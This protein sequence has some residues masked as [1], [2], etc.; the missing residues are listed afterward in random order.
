MSVAVGDLSW[1]ATPDRL[2]DPEYRHTLQKRS[3]VA[4]TGVLYDVGDYEGQLYRCVQDFASE[5]LAKACRT[6][7]RA[8]RKSTVEVV[9][10]FGDVRSM[11]VLTAPCYLNENGDG[12]WT[13]WAHYR[14][15][16]VV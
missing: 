2:L 8:Q 5:A 12:T 10:Q 14:L 4:G 16:Q 3:G 7:V 6:T 13:V 9:D 15:L 11:E 1:A